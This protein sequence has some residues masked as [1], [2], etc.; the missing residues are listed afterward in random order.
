[1]AAAVGVGIFR[2][3]VEAAQAMTRTAKIFQPNAAMR[4]HYDRRFG[5]WLR[6]V[7]AMDPIW[8]ELS[9]SEPRP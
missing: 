7:D 3:E 4:A 1:M 5:L 2:D 8:R 9:T 6:L